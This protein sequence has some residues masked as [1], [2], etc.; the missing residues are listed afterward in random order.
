MQ[1]NVG[2]VAIGRNEGERLKICLSSLATESAKVVYV[3]S[4]SHDGSASYA[5]AQ[6]VKVVELS[7][8]KPFSAAR[9]RNEG[10]ATLLGHWPSVEYIMFIDG[11]CEL[12]SGF[13]SEAIKAFQ[14][15][16]EAAIVTGHCKERHPDAT[17][18]NL[19]CDLEW[20]RAC[21][22]DRSERR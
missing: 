22:T 17:L 7:E 20:E 6:G 13:V 12:L 9:A 10:A 3:D 19:L 16:H 1:D 2:F 21:R 15:S 11:D 18:Y 4:G 8:D 5:Q 14:T